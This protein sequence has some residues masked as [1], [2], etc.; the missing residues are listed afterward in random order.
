MEAP[1]HHVDEEIA[2]QS[3][4]VLRHLLFNGK[5]LGLTDIVIPCVDQSS[6]ADNSATERLVS[7]LR[8]ME[9]P[10][11]MFGINLSL[12]TDLPPQPFAELLD[13]FAS[14][15]V[16][17]NYDTGNSAA[18]GYD[19]VEELSCYGKK[20]TDIHIKDRKCGGGS[21][22]LGS[23]NVQ[24]RRFFETLRPFNYSG[25]F[26]MQAYRDDDLDVFKQ[27]MSWFCQR[28]VREHV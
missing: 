3:Q 26:V 14:G 11:E 13:K 28:Y 10:A 20:I 16:T 12:E 15:R 4:R 22:P 7:W 2:A 8:P 23:G 19:P 9:E 25:P 18:L 17:V 6:L 5:K 24:F 1:L 21:V 27:Q